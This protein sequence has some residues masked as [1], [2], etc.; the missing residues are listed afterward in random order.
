MYEVIL[1]AAI[2]TI[3]CVMLYTVLGKSVGKGPD[4]PLNLTR[5]QAPEA[6]AMVSAVQTV[7]SIPGLAKIIEMD[8][9][10]SEAHFVSGAKGAYAMIL[11][12]FAEPDKEMLETLL[13]PKV[14]EVYLAAITERESKDLRQVTDLARLISAEIT[15]GETQGKAMKISVRYKAELASALVNADGET[16]QGDPNVLATID[17]VWCYTRTAGSKD[18][19]WKLDDVAPSTGDELAADP[20]PDTKA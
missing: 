13:T 2:A 10:F 20:T 3:V 12:A 14:Y 7:P 1:Y 18:P 4:E 15:H 19:N 5:T 17:E 11:E 16:V 6:P 8:K 9:E